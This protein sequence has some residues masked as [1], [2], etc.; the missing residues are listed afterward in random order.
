[1]SR[2]ALVDLGPLRESPA[3]RRL[4]VGQGLSAVGGQLT[5]FAVALQMY[6]LTGSSAAVGG[7][8]LAVAVP[9]LALAVLGGSLGDAVD[10]RRLVLVTSSLQAGV[11]VLFAAQALAGLR[12]P[13]VLYLLVVVQSLVGSVNAPARRTFMARLLPRERLAAGAALN[14]LT[15]QLAAVLGPAAAG[16]LAAGWGLRACYLVDAVSFGAALYGVARLPAMPP[17]PGAPR[18]GAAAIREGLGFVRSGGEVAGAFLADLSMALVA[19]PTA[20]LPA[21]VAE[22]FGARPGV[23]GLLT[24]ASA[25]GGVL[26]SACSGLVGRIERP[27]RAAL[28]CCAG[29]G[30]AV[31]AL[32]PV[33]A[34]WPTVLLLAVA[35]A[36]DTTAV[37]LHSTVVQLVT[38]DRL[39]GRISALEY[40][41]GIGGTQLGRF[42]AGVAGTL[43]GTTVAVTGGGLAGVG[44]AALVA[45]L[46]PAFTRYRV[47]QEPAARAA[48]TG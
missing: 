23:L 38:P 26:G 45:A 30:L 5:V 14:T 40:V 1:M 2:A 21:L 17:L 43:T 6:R 11:S 15:L 29:Y 32:G 31:A 42:R 4:W 12:S 7:L 48:V 34:L 24:A 20:L 18:P 25:V 46:L 47:R 3:F 27:G 22:R 9:N 39:R 28:V 35:G 8:G 16:L 13:A 36:A 37:V 10:R 44:A 19:S 41:V 33:H